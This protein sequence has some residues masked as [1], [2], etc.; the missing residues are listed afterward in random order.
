MHENIG[1]SLFGEYIGA[2]IYTSGWAHAMR[3]QLDL[4][5]IKK[6]GDKPYMLQHFSLL[7]KV[8]SREKSQSPDPRERIG[9]SS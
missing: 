2:I 3:V 1:L 5:K 4:G 7:H 8:N 6:R 9:R